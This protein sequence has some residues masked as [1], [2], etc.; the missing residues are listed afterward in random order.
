[1]TL[2]M[3][4][5]KSAGGTDFEYRGGPRGDKNFFRF[6]ILNRELFGDLTII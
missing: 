1:M 2:K 3:W 4:E 6:L 5:K